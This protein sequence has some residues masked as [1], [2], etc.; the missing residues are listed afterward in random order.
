MLLEF[1]TYRFRAHSMYDPELYRSKEEVAQWMERDPVTTFARRLTDAR[2]VSDAGLSALE[3]GVAAEI[4][5]AVAE[6]EAGPWEP[7]TDLLKDIQAAAP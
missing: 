6:A 4:A 3:Q 1:L 5:A 2:V 7:V